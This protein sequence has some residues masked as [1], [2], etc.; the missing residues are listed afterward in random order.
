MSVSSKID[1]PRDKASRANWKVALALA[2]LGL[3]VSLFIDY[4][5]YFQNISSPF[6]GSQA[7]ASLL[8]WSVILGLS[9]AFPLRMTAKAFRSYIKTA[10]GISVYV[11][12]TSLHILVYGIILET[13]VATIFPYF[14]DISVQA[15]LVISSQPLYPYSTLSLFG[16]FFFNPNL[17]ALVPPIFD[18]S[19]SLYSICMAIIIGVLVQV[20]VMRTIELRNTCSII[21]RSTTFIALPVIGV[22]GGASCCLSL[23]LFVTLLAAPSISLASPSIISAYFLTYFLFPPSTAVILKLNF[24]STNRVKRALSAARLESR[25]A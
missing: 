18:I 17:V 22:V 7:F 9:F 19:L 21:R 13:I 8:F 15:G 1:V 11:V 4:L 12:Y 16:N 20:N 2:T 6:N 5:S 25:V 3:T 10:R 23:P 24:D 14:W